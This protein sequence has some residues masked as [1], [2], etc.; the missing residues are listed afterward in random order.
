[1]VPAAQRVYGIS[2]PEEKQ[3]KE[4]QTAQEEAARRDHRVIGKDQEL[5][6]F[7]PLS[8]G[9]AFFMPHGAR[10]YNTLIQFLRAEYRNRGYT[11]VISPNIYN[12][13]LWVTSGHW[14]AYRGTACCI[15]PAAARQTAVHRVRSRAVL[16]P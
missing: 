5:F 13:Q 12:H 8:P 6:F 16:W 3:L 2:F 9:S 11:E 14:Q 10:V 1:M 7:D 4:W 15:L